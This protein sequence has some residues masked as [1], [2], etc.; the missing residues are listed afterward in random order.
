MGDLQRAPVH[1][2]EAV[3]PR[4]MVAIRFEDGQIVRACAE[5]Y[6]GSRPRRSSRTH[7][8]LKRKEGTGRSD[9]RDIARLAEGGR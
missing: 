1:A 7:N 2:C 3:N 9:E 5:S 8:G 4:R 6:S